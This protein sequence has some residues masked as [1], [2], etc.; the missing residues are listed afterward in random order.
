MFW[1]G[2]GMRDELTVNYLAHDMLGQ[3]EQIFVSR[4][5]LGGCGHG[6]HSSTSALISRE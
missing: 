5:F 6:E 4:E 2:P 1:R 3:I